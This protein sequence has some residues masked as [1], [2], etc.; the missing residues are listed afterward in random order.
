MNRLLNAYAKVMCHAIWTARRF[1]PARDDGLPDI[2]IALRDWEWAGWHVCE[3]CGRHARHRFI[4]WI[5]PTGPITTAECM[6]C[7]F[8]A[9]L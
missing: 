7:G 2:P 1:F 3:N 8:E 5:E 4:E 9:T 6:S